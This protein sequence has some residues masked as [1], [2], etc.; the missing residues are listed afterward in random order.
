[1]L[2]TNNCSSSGGLYKQLTVFYRALICLKHVEDNLIE[3]N[4]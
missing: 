2:Q 4:Y 1:M 3:I